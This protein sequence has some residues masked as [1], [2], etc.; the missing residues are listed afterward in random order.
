MIDSMQLG[1]I[2]M[3]YAKYTE[4]KNFQPMNANFGILPELQEKIRDKKLRYSKLAQ[5]ALKDLNNI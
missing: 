3:N 2:M 5:R 4:N 1:S